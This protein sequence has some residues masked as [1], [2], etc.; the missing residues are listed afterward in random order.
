MKAIIAAAVLSIG[1][2]AVTVSSISSAQQPSQGPGTGG[3][4]R[5][6]MMGGYGAGGYGPGMMGGGMMGGYG[7]GAGMMRGAG[8]WGGGGYGALA[9]PDLSDEQREKIARIQEDSRAKNWNAMGQM[10]SEQFKLRQMYSADKV[11][12]AA[13]TEQQRKVDEI[14]LGML[15]SR[16]EGRNQI[17]ALLTKEQKQ[18]FRSFGPWWS[19]EQGLE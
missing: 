11:D 9:I 19:Q 13:F 5:G 8:G 3:P 7:G 16:I 1:M 10:R 15:K 14:R 6:A 4:G 2:A 18:Q 12:P 17:D